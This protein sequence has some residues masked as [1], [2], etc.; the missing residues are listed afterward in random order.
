MELLI[1]L[2][3]IFVLLYSGY[4]WLLIIGLF[5]VK[6]RKTNE[7]VPKITFSIIVPFRNEEHNLPRLLES[8]RKIK[9]PTEL[10]EIILIDDFS[11]DKS[12]SIITNWRMQNGLFHTTVIENLLRSGSPKKDA[13]NRAIPIVTNEWVLTTDADCILPPNILQSLSTYIAQN[14]VEMIVGP[15]IYDG[16]NS[17]LH[18]F[19]RLDMVSL[20]G[21]TIGSFGIKK[22]FMCNGAN[23]SYSKKFFTD[24]G[25]F[26]GNLN[27]ASGDDVLLLQKAIQRNPSKVGY[28]KSVDAIVTTKAVDSWL[29]LINQR[30]RWAAKAKVYNAVFGE[31]LAFAVFLGNFSIV[32]AVMLSVFKVLSIESL[33]LLGGIKLV[34]DFILLFKSNAFLNRRFIFPFFAAI[35]YPFLTVLIAFNTIFGTYNWKGRTF[36][37]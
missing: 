32:I 36:K 34:P 27:V 1:I 4:I 26:D 17:L 24:L 22:P 14:E 25:G 23:F 30:T 8:F 5:K 11:T 15:V 21:A 28:N 2:L 13:I 16:N 35:L 12:V 29:Q 7:S 20:Q 10:F 3:F 31:D 37:M 9:Y 19:Q 6:S 33:I 18:H